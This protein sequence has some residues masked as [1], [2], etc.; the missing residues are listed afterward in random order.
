MSRTSSVEQTDIVSVMFAELFGERTRDN[1]R[2]SHLDRR[3]LQVH[4]DGLR[5]LQNHIRTSTAPGMTPY[6]WR[7]GKPRNCVRFS[8]Y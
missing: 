6:K 5:D 3:E 4:A 7:E 8:S 1:V 2:I